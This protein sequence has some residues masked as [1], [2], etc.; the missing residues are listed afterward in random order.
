MD[1]KSLK[2]YS[3]HLW[4]LDALRKSG[5]CIGNIQMWQGKCEV[6]ISPVMKNNN[7]LGS[8]NIRQ[9][10]LIVNTYLLF[11]HDSS[12]CIVR[13]QQVYKILQYVEFLEVEVEQ[14]TLLLNESESHGLLSS[15]TCVRLSHQQCTIIAHFFCH[16]LHPTT[17]WIWSCSSSL[18]A[19]FR[20]AISSWERAQPCI[21]DCHRTW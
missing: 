18:S 2:L 13:L 8:S 6:F 10:F 1:I 11:P 5:T 17:S 9:E 21:K 7:K 19:E 3:W 20:E 15:R 4:T 16:L 14:E 12:L